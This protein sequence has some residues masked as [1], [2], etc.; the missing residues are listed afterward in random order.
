[1]PVSRPPRERIAI[2][3]HPDTL[4]RARYWASRKDQSLNE[5]IVEAIEERI[6]R[7]NLDY[8][9]PTLE[10]ARLNQLIDLIQSQSTTLENLEQVIIKT[11]D[12]I[13]GLAR[14]DNY[15]LVSEDGE[16]DV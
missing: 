6:S 12:S 16:L 4:E 7:I 10:Q 14:G 11:G 13:T 1:M 8:D 5:W 15:L 9:L 2:R 3:V